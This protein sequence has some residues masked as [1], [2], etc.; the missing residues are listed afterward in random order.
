MNRSLVLD[1]NVLVSAALH[2]D[3]LPGL[4]VQAILKREVACFTCPAVVAEYWDVLTRPKFERLGFPPP[5]FEPFLAEAH[6]LE[7]DPHP[8]PL[9]GPDPDGLV[10]LAL[11]K[12]AGAVLVTGNLADFPEAIRRGVQVLA[13]KPYLD[14][15]ESN[16]P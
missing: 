14:G 9:A 8:W 4:L 6:Q 5:W 16:L 7:T 3:H 2:L 11:A 10:F 15:I 12:R 1:T 13:P